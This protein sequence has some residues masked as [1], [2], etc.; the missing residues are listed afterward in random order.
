[1]IV[2]SLSFCGQLLVTISPNNI[3]LAYLG[4]WLRSWLRLGNENSWRS[5]RNKDVRHYNLCDPGHFVFYPN[6]FHSHRTARQI[7]IL[8]PILRLLILVNGICN[9]LI[10]I[11]RLS[12]RQNILMTLRLRLIENET[13]LLLCHSDTE[14]R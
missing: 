8:R 1:M 11:S 5:S 12:S 10:L 2:S 14:L 9:V 4:L 3:T 6:I 13:G 7:L